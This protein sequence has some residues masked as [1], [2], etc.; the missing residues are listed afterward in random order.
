M[1]I[2]SADLAMNVSVQMLSEISC[3]G[4]PTYR[5]VLDDKTT[6]QTTVTTTSIACPFTIL[7]NILVIIAVKQRRELQKHSNILLAILAV[8]DVLVGAI[9]MPLTTTLDVLVLL[10]YVNNPHFCRILFI[11]QLVLYSLCYSSVYH[12]TLIAWERYVA[13]R[14][15]MEYRSIVTKG[16]IRKYS[17]IAWLVSLVIPLPSRIMRMVGVYIDYEYLR[18]IN[19]LSLLPAAVCI[20]LIGYFYLMIYLRVRRRKNDREMSQ[21]GAV[22]NA[23]KV[24]KTTGILTAALI[25]SFIPSMTVICFGDAL[26]ALQRSSFFLWAMMLS[27]LNSLFNPIL[28]CFRDHRFR[29]AILEM[30]KI[31]KPEFKT[32]K[33]KGAQNIRRSCTIG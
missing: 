11:N 24:A 8:A 33:D 6:F 31:K 12:L 7:L 22:V 28:Y 27:Q 21:V 9:S 30:L 23:T 18:V 17:S 20:I 10:R 32:W 26:P 29:N 19:I 1:N 13:I 15:C 25:V 4:K 2:C 16:R 5:W 3:Q 14:K